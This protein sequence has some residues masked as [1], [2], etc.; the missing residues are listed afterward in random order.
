VFDTL[1]PGVAF[2]GSSGGL[3]FRSTDGGAH[4]TPITVGA[5]DE[6]FRVIGQASGV[7]SGLFYAFSTGAPPVTSN[8]IGSGRVYVSQNDGVTW[9]A[10]A[11]QPPPVEGFYRGLGRGIALDPT[12]QTVV[13][14]DVVGGIARSTNGGQ[15]WTH[16]LLPT[17]T[18]VYGLVA[19]PAHPGT[20]YVAG[21]TVPQSVATVWKSTDYGKT[22]TPNSGIQ[23]LIPAGA[24]NPQAYAIAVQPGTG[25]LFATYFYYSAT[26][27][28]EVGGVARSLDGGV[29]WTALNS[30]ILPDYIPGSASGGIVFDPTTPTTVYLST[31]GGYGLT[32]GGGFYKSIDSGSR[33]API[34]NSLPT[35]GGFVAAARPALTGYPAEILN[36]SPGITVSANSGKTW[37]ASVAG[38]DN[39]PITQVVDDGKTG[40]YYAITETQVFHTVNSGLAWSATGAWKGS[41]TPLSI[42]TDLTRT[43]PPVYVATVNNLWRS[44][45]G[46]TNWA[47]ILPKLGTGL[48]ITSVF[49]D[50]AGHVYATDSG[51]TLYISANEGNTWTVVPIGAA[52]DTFS[53][54]QQ[55]PVVAT[56][57]PTGNA[58]AGLM[59]AGLTSGLWVSTNYGASW[60]LSAVQ[61]D[62]VNKQF[63]YLAVMQASPYTVVA[64]TIM[65]QVVSFTPGGTAFSPV[66]SNI[67]GAQFAAAPGGDMFASAA[68]SSVDGSANAFA[69]SANV[70]KALT[71][72]D[73]N[74]GTYVSATKSLLF[75]SDGGGV[76]YAA[77]YTAV[78]K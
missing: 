56:N 54:Y 67:S 7:A 70:A 58:Q 13:L 40:G 12:G 14:S 37:A 39:V 51:R 2:A 1:H 46:G 10:L 41:Q 76:T 31:N 66:A 71:A 78:L 77:P 63:A 62:P 24:Q 35:G 68:T 55:N 4:W 36:G 19:D 23:A 44:F 74:E 45:S 28:S 22:W 8:V 73:G 64:A 9:T 33:W 59:Y 20:L 27:G 34:G 61:P 38:F 6:E 18:R 32:D 29:T 60:A 50:A 47:S 5:P 30:G 69:T 43:T 52:T 25:T 15:T 48:R 72:R 49:T 16:P 3:I 26:D 57:A 75:I 17:V 11:H 42:A 21:R 65:Q 53:L